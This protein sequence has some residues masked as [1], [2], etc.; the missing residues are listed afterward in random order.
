MRALRVDTKVKKNSKTTL[1]GNF[2]NRFVSTVIG[3]DKQYVQPSCFMILVQLST[4]GFVVLQ[5]CLCSGQ[6]DTK[7]YVRHRYIGSV[8]KTAAF[9]SAAVLLSSS[10]TS[11]F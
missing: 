1:M 4:F 5:L 9:L 8:E 3:N 6:V 2:E 10:E 7:R 11:T